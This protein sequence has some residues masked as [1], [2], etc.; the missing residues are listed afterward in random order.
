MIHM[1]RKIKIRNFENDTH[2]GITVFVFIMLGMTIMLYL[3]GFT[4]MWTQYETSAQADDQ[5]NITRSDYTIEWNPLG[6]ILNFMTKNAMYIGAGIGGLLAVGLLGWF[7]RFDLSAF[8]MY[9]IPIG[10]LAVF[11]NV[12]VFPVY[13]LSDEVSKFAI[14]GFP[15]SVFL[16]AFFNLWFIMAIIEYVRSG[17]TS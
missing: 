8:Y 17:V 9:V 15:V 13:P 3:F 2:G 6:A 12:I 7:L 16:L 14:G 1:K 4:N 5:T 10:I 11:L